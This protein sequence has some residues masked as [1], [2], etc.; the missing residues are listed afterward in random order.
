M[1]R[2]LIRAALLLL[3]SL[4][5]VTVPAERLN[6]SLSPRQQI[7]LQLDWKTSSI[8]PDKLDQHEIHR[9]I[10]HTSNVDT[11]LDTSKYLGKEVRIYLALPILVRGLSNP[12]GMNFSWTTNGLF[13]DGQLTPGNRQLIFEGHV[14]SPVM[15]DNFHFTF[16]LDARDLTQTLRLEP[17]YE[18]E[19]LMP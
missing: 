2:T 4:L 14:T 13:L 8:D 10:A 9:V 3:C 11:R 6:D 18:I 17:V 12:Q 1:G 19:T 7:N 16:E 5:S 15:I